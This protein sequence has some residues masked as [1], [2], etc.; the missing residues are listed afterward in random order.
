MLD[1]RDNTEAGANGGADFMHPDD[2]ERGQPPE[3]GS[4]HDGPQKGARR[5]DAKL[6]KDR[7][8]HGGLPPWKLRYMWFVGLKESITLLLRAS[9]LRPYSLPQPRLRQHFDALG[10]GLGVAGVGGSH[11]RGFGA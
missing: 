5:D 1:V 8:F 10:F 11:R 7:I 4:G 6:M 9:Q 3:E 2:T